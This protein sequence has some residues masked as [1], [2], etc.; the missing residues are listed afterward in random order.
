MKSLARKLR[1]QATDAELLIWKHL[2]ARQ[3]N[4]YKFRRQHVIEPYIVDFFCMEAMLIIEVDGGQHTDQRINDNIRTA[5]LQSQGY[6][7]IRFWNNEI[8]D[9]IDIV[10]EKILNILINPSP[11]PSPEGRGGDC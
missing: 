1:K 10:L 3:L 4:G 8:V 7:V 11:Q 2:R 5:Y 6:R 9:D